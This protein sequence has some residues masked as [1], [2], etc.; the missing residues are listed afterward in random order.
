MIIFCGILLI[1]SSAWALQPLAEFLNQAR[2]RSFDARE[3]DVAARQRSLESEAAFGR[4]LPTVSARGVYTRNQYETAVTLPNGPSIVITP[5]NQLDAIF[6]VDLPILDLASHH[7]YRQASRAADVA[8]SQR[9][10]VG[11]RLDQAVTRLY[12]SFLGAGA[13]F[14][15]S[16]RSLA[17]A[18]DNLKF[19]NTRRELGVASELDQERARANL[20]RAKQDVTDAQLVGL[21]VARQLQTL[22]GLTPTPA[23]SYLTDDL[24]AEPPLSAW[25]SAQDTPEERVQAALSEMAREG[26]KAAKAAL[27]PTLSANA[28]ERV[29]NAGGF[30]GHS[31][32]Y[33]LQA[34]LSWRL[35]YSTYKTAQAQALGSEAQSIHTARVRRGVDDA[36]FDAYHRVVSGIARSASARAQAEASKKAEALALE[37]YK[38]GT[39]TQLDVT[40]SQR[41][42]FQAEAARIQADAD[43]AFSRALLRIASGQSPVAAGAPQQIR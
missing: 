22:T 16:K 42:A 28:Q 7:R 10:L 21:T 30:S 26:E 5:Q 3:A 37:R 34:V 20:E 14:E 40:Q 11:A 18:E 29:S 38:A 19:I 15:A 12:F 2:S 17:I 35:D 24:H 36:I 41:D 23:D 1:S 4:L 6:Q 32:T 27:L 9:A 31:S 8:E 43:L 33:A 25:L 13:L 39:L